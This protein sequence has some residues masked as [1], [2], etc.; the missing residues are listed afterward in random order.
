MNIDHKFEIEI[1]IIDHCNLNCDNCNHFSN[2]A[3]P[4]FMSLEEFE[5]SLK[6]IR[7]EFYPHGL[8]RI[9]ILGGEPLLHPQI[10]EFCDLAKQIFPE[11]NF[12]IDILTNGIKLNA[13]SE[14]DLKYITQRAHLSITPY[15]KVEYPEYAKKMM[16]YGEINN[17]ASRLFFVSTNI[18]L[19]PTQSA[20]Y[21]YQRCSKYKL[22]CYFV[23]NYKVFICPF[24][25]CAHILNERFGTKIELQEGDYLDLNTCTYQDL[26][27]L[28]QRGPKHICRYCNSHC[29][30][31]FW[32]NGS[33]RK[34]EDYLGI[35]PKELYVT[36]YN[37]YDKIYNGKLIFEEFRKEKYLDKVKLIDLIDGDY[38]ITKTTQTLSRVNRK[39][40]I[41]IPFFNIN[42]EICFN[43]FNSLKNQSIIDNCHIYLISDNSEYDNIVYDAFDNKGLNITFLKTEKRMGPGGA[44]QTGI[45]NSF[46]PY[47]FFLDSDDIL[48][49]EKGLEEM[50]KLAEDKDADIVSGVSCRV[51]WNLNSNQKDY[52]LWQPGQTEMQ[53]T[54]C[55]LYKRSFLNDNNIR[56]KHV[57]I[58]EDADF[59]HQVL[60]AQPKVYLYNKETYLYQRN[61]P[62]S[63][64]CQTS[65]FDKLFCRIIINLKNAEYKNIEERWNDILYADDL[66]CRYDTLDS[67]KIE[68]IIGITFYFGIIFYE[69]LNPTEKKKIFIKDK[70][71]FSYLLQERILNNEIGLKIKGKIYTTKDQYKNLIKEIIEQ[72]SIKESLEKELA[73]W[74]M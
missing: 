33:Q 26:L 38:C 40:D 54:H 36:N 70:D 37:E 6:R 64:G 24:S 66:L 23:K 8:E 4:W 21:N 60:Y 12:F 1:Q 9:M 73:Q 56:F 5:F 65:L 50:L 57:F 17:L 28:Y 61:T 31:V 52:F 2:L 58:A 47:L 41:I 22:P 39:I 46:N 44:R 69:S 18:D 43:L 55:L 14:D 72:S 62:V 68:T 51:D 29:F 16:N 63:I 10:K 34:L 30:P 3:K 59:I 20:E 7:K 53:D 19:I 42:S 25:G 67:D 15:P 48:V 45:D 49:N 35:E 11:R 74:I 71:N 32:S 13:I 27:N